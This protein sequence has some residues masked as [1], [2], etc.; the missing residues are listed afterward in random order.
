MR[1]VKRG[2]QSLG[3]YVMLVAM[4]TII[5]T[6]MHVVYVRRGLQGR[7][8][9]ASDS[10]VARMN[11]AVNQTHRR[12]YEPLYTESAKTTGRN[13]T[14]EEQYYKDG[15]YNKTQFFS[16]GSHS[17]EVTNVGVINETD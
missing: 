2:G 7:L 6:A 14:L 5:V 8:K 4:A 16:V 1:L 15:V 9:D 3:E 12:Q 13:E 11:E 17:V 10:L